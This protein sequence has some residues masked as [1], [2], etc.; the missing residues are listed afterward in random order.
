[1][2][3]IKTI[4]EIKQTSAVRYGQTQKRI[5]TISDY[6]Q[7]PLQEIIEKAIDNYF[8]ELEKIIENKN[9][10]KKDK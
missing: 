3:W 10:N 2:F 1:M 6:I 4:K 7:G 8:K 5:N 9:S